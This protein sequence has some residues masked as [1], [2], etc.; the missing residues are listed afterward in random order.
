MLAGI[1]EFLTQTRTKNSC[2]TRSSG[3]SVEA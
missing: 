1:F 2:I 3:C